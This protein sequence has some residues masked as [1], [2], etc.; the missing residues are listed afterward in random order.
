M[1]SW[2]FANLKARFRRPQVV[3]DPW[4]HSPYGRILVDARD[5]AA[6]LVKRYRD[7]TE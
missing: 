5:R 2:L 7:A 1:L 6:E 3:D 4:L